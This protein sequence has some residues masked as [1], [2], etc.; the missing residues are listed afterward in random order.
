MNFT[1]IITIYYMLFLIL[2]NGI[3]TGI[4]YILY[5]RKY[6]QN[7][8]VFPKKNTCVNRFQHMLQKRVWHHYDMYHLLYLT[9]YIVSSLIFMIYSR[10]TPYD[11]LKPT[12]TFLAVHMMI[13][14]MF[15]V[16]YS[17]LTFFYD[18]SYNHLYIYHRWMAYYILALSIVHTLAY[19]MNWS[20]P[21][22]QN[23]PFSIQHLFVPIPRTFGTLATLFVVCIC[24]LS[25]SFIRRN[26]YTFFSNSHVIFILFFYIATV[27]HRPYFLPYFIISM[28]IFLL[29][30][31][32]VFCL[33]Y[34]PTYNAHIHSIDDSFIKL[35]FDKGDRFTFHSGQHVYINVPEISMVEWHPFTIVSSPNDR[36]IELGIKSLGDYTKQLIQFAHDKHNIR[37][38]VYGPFGKFP[39]RYDRYKELILISSGIG[40]T[41]MLSILRDIFLSPSFHYD[42]KTV[43]L[44]WV[45]KDLQLFRYYEYVINEMITVAN[46][47]NELPRFTVF[48]YHKDPNNNNIG[49]LKN[50]SLNISHFFKQFTL[51]NE[52]PNR[53][54]M[55]IVC[56]SNHLIYDTWDA[57]S[58]YS[59]NKI[60]YDYY[61]DVFEF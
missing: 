51:N 35:Y 12:G 20:R 2:L 16:K 36:R 59:S 40:I 27:L 22:I 38:H 54:I 9:I 19:I 48:I 34:L 24:G 23:H 3:Y 11:W 15:S 41:P 57:C 4:R 1:E 61:Y 42:I 14:M 60:Q 39:F 49:Y 17:I 29:N 13:V 7:I 18:V 8:R 32:L 53:R 58:E 46:Q 10:I 47:S 31:C 6:I 50:E 55:V 56:G 25:I 5:M 44:I 45:C 26:H 21:E 33:G 37:I 30:K 52:S 43:T 28:M